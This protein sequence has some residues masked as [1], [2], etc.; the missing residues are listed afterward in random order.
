MFP[1]VPIALTPEIQ[2]QISGVIED[3]SIGLELSGSVLHFYCKDNELLAILRKHYGGL[4]HFCSLIKI[5][6]IS[7]K[8]WVEGRAIVQDRFRVY[9]MRSLMQNIGYV[10]WTQEQGDLGPFW[11]FWQ[12]SESLALVQRS[13]D[14]SVLWVD[15]TQLSRINLKDLDPV[16]LRRRCFELDTMKRAAS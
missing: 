10:D 13:K 7:V 1:N 12:N 8:L 14:I 11:E 4:A 2:C 15:Q 9:D 6:R 16:E 5:Q 3:I